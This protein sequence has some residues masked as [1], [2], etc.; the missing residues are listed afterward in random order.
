MLLLS[1]T[2]H[3]NAGR[4]LW[5]SDWTPER[6]REVYGEEGPHGYGHNYELEVAVEG[7]VDPETS[8]VVNLTELDRILR[9]EVDGPLDHRNLNL[10][11]PEFAAVPPTAER[12]AA[13]IWERVGARIRRE[14]WPC[15]LSRLR[16]KLEPGFAVEIEN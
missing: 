1:R 6:N 7:R 16:L 8:M 4:S 14:G 11:V 10:D 15:R 9:D 2:M 12:L 13:W 5:R 3:F